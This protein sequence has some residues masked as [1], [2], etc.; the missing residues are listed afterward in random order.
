M[1]KYVEIG[2]WIRYLTLLVRGEAKFFIDEK[3]QAKVFRPTRV[4]KEVLCVQV[5]LIRF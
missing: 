3:I 4:S 2:Y 1:E 5:V